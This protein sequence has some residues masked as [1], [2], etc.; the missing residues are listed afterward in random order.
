MLKS[1]RGCVYLHFGPFCLTGEGA[2]PQL[3]ATLSQSYHPWP[4]GRASPLTRRYLHDDES[5]VSGV[6]Q[7]NLIEP[8][9]PQRLE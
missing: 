4:L 1:H 3:V 5:G 7:Q 2:G 6:I 9:L 8:H